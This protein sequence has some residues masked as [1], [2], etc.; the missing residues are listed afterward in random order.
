MKEDTLKINVEANG[1]D[2][3][4][5]KLK[6]LGDVMDEFP[7]QVIIKNCRDCAINVYPKQ[8]KI[9]RDEWMPLPKPYEK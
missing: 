5:E 9:I 1:I 4:T 2:E 3:V 6:E 8:I 7:S